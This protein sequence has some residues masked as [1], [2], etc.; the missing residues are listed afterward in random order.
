[1][2]RWTSPWVSPGFALSELV[3]SWAASTPEGTLVQVEVRG[4]S[5]GGT[6]S[7]WDTLG[8]WARGDA[9]FKRTSVGSQTDDLARVATDTWVAKYGGRPAGSCASACSAGP[10]RR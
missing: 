6:R 2:G 5:E 10:A 1:M 8:R 9:T 4:T 3:P 7:S